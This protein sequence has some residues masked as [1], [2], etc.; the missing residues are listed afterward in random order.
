MEKRNKFPPFLTG[1]DNKV[2]EFVHF[3]A[4]GGYGTVV[5]VKEKSR[6]FFAIKSFLTKH[7]SDDQEFE[8][9]QKTSNIENVVK[10]FSMFKTEY[11][12]HIVMEMLEGGDLWDNLYDFGPIPRVQAISIFRKL[13]ITVAELLMVGLYPCDL[14]AENLYYDRNKKALKILDLGGMKN[15]K[16]KIEVK[17]E[18]GTMCFY[19]PEYHLQE[20]KQDIKYWKENGSIGE[21]HLSWMLG[22]ILWHLLVGEQKC[23]N[24]LEDVKNFKLEIPSR[25]SG[26]QESETYHLVIQLLALDP[27]KRLKFWLLHQ[28]LGIKSFKICL[29]L[30]SFSSGCPA[31]N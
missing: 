14:K 9:F 6:G 27:A 23:I 16:K 26:L 2:Y 22:L 21:L 4:R 30:S 17:K 20:R 24:S 1:D 7:D 15:M 13:V 28:K 12:T 11:D 10:A 31:I 25:I 18:N 5:K 8:A 29:S 19:P 3:I